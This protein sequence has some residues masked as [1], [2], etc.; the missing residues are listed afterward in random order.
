MKSILIT[1]GL[2]FVGSHLADALLLLGYQVTI[3]DNCQSNAVEPSYFAG[4]CETLLEKIETACGKLGTSSGRRF[5]EIYHLASIVGPAGVLDYAGDIAR[6]VI[7]SG[8]VAVALALDHGA[9][10]LVASTSEVYGRTGHLSESLDCIIS[11]DVT[12]RLEYAAAKLTSEIAVLN[13][14]KVTDLKVNVIRPFNI[15]G[16]R[17]KPEGGFVLPRFVVAAL[18][19]QPL[20]VF[21]DGTQIRAFTDVRDIV[22]G[23]M[24][25]MRVDRTGMVL[26]LGNQAN[27]ISMLSLAQEVKRLSHSSSE[28]GLVDPKTLFGDLYEE[29]LERV[30]DASKAI[31]E[32]NWQPAYTLEQTILDTIAFYRDSAELAQPDVAEQIAS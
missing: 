28:I 1:G 9:K 2:G 27:E 7:E 12:V 23:L 4:R 5:D 11:P 13:K 6:S 21:G 10:L 18:Q 8:D 30:P 26:N 15:A 32:L 22:A 25:T 19:G 3:V 20:T 29:G 16:P 31:R 24:A 14:A 17:Q